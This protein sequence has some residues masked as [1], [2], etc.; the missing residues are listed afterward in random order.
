MYRTENVTHLIIVETHFQ[1][2]I[3]HI[4]AFSLLLLFEVFYIDAKQY[5]TIYL[6]T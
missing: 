5:V 4:S 1:N 6:I 3:I 2:A